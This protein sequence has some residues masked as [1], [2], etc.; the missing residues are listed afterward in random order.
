MWEDILKQGQGSCWTL[1]TPGTMYFD[2]EAF[3]DL[4]KSYQRDCHTIEQI[5][6]GQPD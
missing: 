6:L 3:E 4:L 5:Y 1:Q 2:M